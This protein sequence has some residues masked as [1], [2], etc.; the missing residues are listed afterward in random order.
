MKNVLAAVSLTALAATA[1]QAEEI[2][3]NGTIK[4]VFEK[5]CIACHGSNAPEYSEFKKD[6]NTWLKNGVGMRMDTYSHLISFAGWPNTGAL[7]R[8]LD[9]GKGLNEGKA[10]NMYQHLGVEEHERQE[11]LALFKQWVGNWNLKRWAD[12]SKDELSGV[13]ARY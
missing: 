12:I 13:K 5:H 6:K 11:N 3:W 7:M 10:G 8:R 1:V 2:T 9:D 4:E